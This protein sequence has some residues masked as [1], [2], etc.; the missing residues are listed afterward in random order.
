MD[1]TTHFP[2]GS[3]AHE[4]AM[5]RKRA[6]YVW[7]GLFIAATVIAIL[8]L[9]IL[10][11]SIIDSVFGYT[12]MADTLPLET[13]IEGR[14]SPD[15]LTRMELESLLKE[16]LS[17]GM[18]RKVTYDKALEDRDLTDL[19]ALVETVRHPTS[20]AQNV[21]AVGLLDGAGRD[22]K[23]CRGTPRFLYHFQELDDPFVHHCR[24]VE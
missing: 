17:R 14:E 3:L 20:G 18:L 6:G 8:F 23:V 9:A 4:R 10:L 21:G 2:T 19:K 1:T 15:E 12:V 11:I 16:N 13:L 22:R 7:Q 24:S 5:R